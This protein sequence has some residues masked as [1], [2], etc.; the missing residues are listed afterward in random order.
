MLDVG[1]VRIRSLTAVAINF[2]CVFVKRGKA[3]AAAEEWWYNKCYDY[4]I[5]LE[6]FFLYV[7]F[8]NFFVPFYKCVLLNV[9]YTFKAHC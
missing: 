8:F 1:F 4:D 5:S 6:T 3:A 2:I 9:D 7:L